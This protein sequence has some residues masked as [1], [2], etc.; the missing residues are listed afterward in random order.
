VAVVCLPILKRALGTDRLGI[1]SLAWV[2]VGYFGFFDL[3]LSRALT[4]LVAEKLGQKRVEEIPALVWASLWMMAGIGLAGSVTAVLLSR[5]LVTGPLRVPQG[6]Q[7]EALIS[8]YWLSLSIPFVVVTAG[9]RGAL[10]ALQRF[11]LATAIRIPMSVFTYLGPVVVLPF[12]HN[13]VPIMIALVLGRVAACL[14]HFWGCFSAWPALRSQRSFHRSCVG[15]LV[16]FGGWLTVTNIVAPLLVSCDRFVIGSLISVSAVAYYAVPYEVVTRFNFLAGA[17]VGVLFPAFSTTA[18]SDRNRLVFLYECGVKYIFLA[19]FPVTL[20]VV[21]FA[22][23][24]LRLWLGSDFAQNSTHLT[25]LLAIAVFLNGLSQVPFAHIQGAGRPD[26]TAKFHLMELPLYAAALIYFARIGGITGVAV[27]WLL[28]VSIDAAL[29]FFVSW[30]MLPENRFI[31]TK[32]PL[33]S[34]GALGL[35]AYAAYAN[36]VAVR[37]AFAVVV[38]AL[39][40]YAIWKW[41]ISPAEKRALSG[42][43]ATPALAWAR[44]RR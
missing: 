43:R 4:K 13:L 12:S 3:G 36:A 27:A 31:V 19:L 20:V 18:E 7:H 42:L 33:M 37:A 24:G 29:L 6:L 9:L 32:L 23:D 30:R 17:L 25:Q 44:R 40:T 15:P 1:I 35:F 5:W 8:F 41:L 38:C 10:E 39:A 21:A 22:P 11:R 2:I 26:L 28:R 34:L 16:R 14:A